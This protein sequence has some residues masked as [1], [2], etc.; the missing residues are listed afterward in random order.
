ME[1]KKKENN[2][3]F[4]MQPEEAPDF[5]DKERA[6]KRLRAFREL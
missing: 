2:L 6:E 4:Y 3:Y 5:W 1:H